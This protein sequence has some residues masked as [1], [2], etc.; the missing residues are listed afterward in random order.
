MDEFSW[1]KT[2]VVEGSQGEHGAASVI[3]FDPR[4]ITCK[5]IRD[6]NEN[7]YYDEF[8]NKRRGMGGS[9]VSTT[10]EQPYDQHY[11]E[12][13]QQYPQYPQYPPQQQYAPYQQQYYDESSGSGVYPPQQ[14][15]QQPYQGYEDYRQT[16]P[17]QAQMP[18]PQFYDLNNNK[19]NA[20]K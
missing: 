20:R 10:L 1:G 12:Y 3:K 16:S 13:Q 4:S 8:V 14:Y 19:R 2:R 11:D 5:R 7:G 15:P 18:N 17:T 9:S 6:W